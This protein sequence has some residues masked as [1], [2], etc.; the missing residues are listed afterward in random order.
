MPMNYKV[1]A[2]FASVLVIGLFTLSGVVGT[3][4]TYADGF[5]ESATPMQNLT[6]EVTAM[7]TDIIPI[8]IIL[9]V[10]GAIIN[11]VGKLSKGMGG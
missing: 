11:Y 10:F 4:I 3:G 2:I 9:G 8:F 7:L 6:T 1:M 5:A